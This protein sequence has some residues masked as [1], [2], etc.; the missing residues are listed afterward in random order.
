[1]TTIVDA[2]QHLWELA[3]HPQTWMNPE[4]D[5]AINRD[6][7]V[8]DLRAAAASVRPV[9]TVVVQSV[10]DA[11]ETTHLLARAEAAS[12]LI[13]GVVGWADLTAADLDDWFGRWQTGPG[14]HRLVGLRHLVQNEPDAGWLDRPDVRQGLQTATRHGLSYDLL[15][16]GMHLPAAVRV[17]SDL[18][19]TRFILDHLGKPPFQSGDF[20]DWVAHIRRLGKLPNVWAKV[21][22]LVTEAAPGKR[23]AVHLRPAFDVAL[24]AFGPRRLMVGSDWPVCLLAASYTEV[25]ST[26]RELLAPLSESEQQQ[27]LADNAV[28]FYRLQLQPRPV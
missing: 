3:Q 1:M 25:V 13:A 6:F 26:A 5:S 7:V 10:N 14:G 22:G 12:D 24:D 11:D 23:S 28:A 21:S 2:H 8:D 17:A 9:A 27:V 18:P 20:D 19:G 4:T 15:V 16:N